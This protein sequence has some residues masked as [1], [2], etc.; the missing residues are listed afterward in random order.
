MILSPVLVTYLILRGKEGGREGGREREKER[1]KGRG[2]GGGRE[3]GREGERIKGETETRQ[4][5]FHTS[6]S[7]KKINPATP[8]FHSTHNRISC[9]IYILYIH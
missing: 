4:R 5:K 8:F 2:G 9:M 6:F 1:E 3:R 7:C